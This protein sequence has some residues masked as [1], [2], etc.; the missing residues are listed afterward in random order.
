MQIVAIDD[1]P[2][3]ARYGAY[4]VS[5]RLRLVCRREGEDALILLSRE[6]V[7][8]GNPLSMAIYGIALL[9]LG[10]QLREE[11]PTVLQPWYAD[12]CAMMGSAE[13]VAACLLVIQ[14]VGP[15]FGYHPEPE[16]SWGICPLATEAEGKATMA[17]AG[18]Q[19][20]WCRG[21]RYVG[22]YVGSIVMCDEWIDP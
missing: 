17:A 20:N 7:A 5:K 4:L 8:Q 16:K 15:M 13:D 2:A 11:F 14:K 1:S 9:P 3:G 21:L 12:D 22:G 19:I 10:E 6:G 18:L